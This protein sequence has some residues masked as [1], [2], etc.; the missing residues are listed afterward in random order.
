[1]NKETVIKNI[2][3]NYGKYGITR[4][5]IEPL[6]DSG[7]SEGLSYDLI[8][9]TIK[10]ELSKLVGEEFFCTSSDMARAFGVSEEE[11]NR[12]I[13]NSREELIDSGENPDDYFKEMQTMKFMM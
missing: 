7:V 6:I 1:M 11:V 5:I 2:T 3:Y 12:V 9:L 13:E 10:A 8:Y 4:E